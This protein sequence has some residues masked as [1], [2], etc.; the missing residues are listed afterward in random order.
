[1]TILTPEEF[2]QAKQNELNR[3]LNKEE[4]LEFDRIMKLFED[5]INDAINNNFTYPDVYQNKVNPKG[6][7]F[8]GTNKVNCSIKEELLKFGWILYQTHDS[9]DC[10]IFEL[11]PVSEPI[12]R[13]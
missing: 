4:Q 13:K 2:L 6:L 9:Y 1:M 7:T 12:P 10:A 11:R 8:F 3:T 5:S